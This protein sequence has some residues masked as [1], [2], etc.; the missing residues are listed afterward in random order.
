MASHGIREGLGRSGRLGRSCSRPS[1]IGAMR[2]DLEKATEAQSPNPG[3][4]A[5]SSKRISTSVS[6]R[7]TRSPAFRTARGTSTPPT[8]I[9]LAEPRSTTSGTAG[10]SAMSSLA[11][12]R[13]TDESLTWTSQ[14]WARPMYAVPRDNATSLPVSGPETMTATAAG[15][16]TSTNDSLRRMTETVTPERNPLSGTVEWASSS[17]GNGSTTAKVRPRLPGPGTTSCWG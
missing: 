6:P 15:R 17:R 13:E 9:P 8:E 11:W 1:N 12:R 16:P 2:G 4:G 10:C 14:P 5:F 3:P 7:R